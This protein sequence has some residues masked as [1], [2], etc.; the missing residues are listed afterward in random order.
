[1]ITRNG[2]LWIPVFVLLAS[3]HASEARVGTLKKRNVRQLSYT[4]A[5]RI[6]N[7][8]NQKSRQ[9]KST[10]SV[11]TQTRRFL[12]DEMPEELV[13]DSTGNRTSYNV[14]AY[15]KM[16][17]KSK[18]KSKSSMASRSATDEPTDY[19][20]EEPEFPEPTQEPT[21]APD[22]PSKRPTPRPTRGP[23]PR[24]TLDTPAP[25]PSVTTISTPGPTGTTATPG[26]TGITSTPGPTGTTATIGCTENKQD[27]S[28]TLDIQIQWPDDEFAACDSADQ[29]SAINANIQAALN[30][31]FAT[32]VPDWDGDAN[33]GIF[34]FDPDQ[35][36]DN[37]DPFARRALFAKGGIQWRGLQREGICPARN[38]ECEGDYCRFGC[39]TASTTDCGTSGLT[40]WA[41]LAEDV[42][43]RLAGL[44]FDCLGIPEDL[45]VILQII[46]PDS[47]APIPTPPPTLPGATPAPT[48]TGPSPTTAPSIQRGTTLAPFGTAAP[49]IQRGTT[50]APFG[51]AAP[52]IQRGTTL[53]PFGTAAP[54]PALTCTENPRD[55]PVNIDLQID[56]AGAPS[57][58]SSD[59]D[60]AI[61]A[62]IQEA[63]N[64][65][66]ATTVPDWDGDAFWGPFVFDSTQ[67]ARSGGDERRWLMFNGGFLP[68][69]MLQQGTCS[70]RFVDCEGDTCRWGCLTASTTDCG[71]SSITNWGSLDED[72][73]DS[74]VGLGFSCLG[75]PE[76]LEVILVV[77]DPE[78]ETR[79][80]VDHF[81]VKPKAASLDLN[82]KLLQSEGGA[83][84]TV[85]DRVARVVHVESRLKA[86]FFAG[87]ER[88][89]TQAD[90]SGLIPQIAAFLMDQMKKDPLFVVAGDSS[91]GVSVVSRVE[92]EM[93]DAGH[94]VYL[95]D[96]DTNTDTFEL[97]LAIYVNL[98]TDSQL[99]VPEVAKAMTKY[100]MNRFIRYYAWKSEP[101]KQNQFYHTQWVRFVTKKGGK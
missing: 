53:A 12:E 1:M 23:T 43:E 48:E 18:S 13:G 38:V 52:T 58:C 8:N 21:V 62:S 42:R 56:F 7:S 22:V 2:Y 45:E 30:E 27:Y 16:S 92:V 6:G 33:F 91:S 74:L 59:E 76:Q 28:V 35:E 79:S 47:G 100:D 46:D 15:G 50:L 81:E 78:A 98:T 84:A 71:T 4:T 20:T 40:N 86:R 75:D 54:T 77:E 24:P 85:A 90:I 34:V 11:K 73:R 5:S 10:G 87:D 70:E 80:G 57:D 26:P 49:T 36:I 60:N 89:P 61:A 72:V 101:Y 99:T 68:R 66:F 31:N 25:S 82:E 14:T 83:G 63:L 39:L 95:R 29:D 44:G 9:K 97:D 3:L 41:G 93:S 67:E 51:T 96:A 64:S 94:K 88:N 32:S 55:Y 65:N 19:P 69:R 37:V 17:S